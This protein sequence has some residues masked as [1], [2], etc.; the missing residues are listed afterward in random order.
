MY[1][2]ARERPPVAVQPTLAEQ[3]AG[4]ERM[5]DSTAEPAEV[6]FVDVD[7]DGVRAQ[8][9]VPADAA[10]DRVL[11]YFH[12]GGYA[13]CSMRSHSKLVGH[14]ATA[15]GCRGLNVDYRLAPEHPHP[16][17]I[18]DG[19]TAYRWLLAQGLDP[20]HIAVAG[21]SAGGGLAAA[22]LLKAR[23]DGLPLPAAGV[24]LSPWVDLELT[25]DSVTTRVGRDLLVDAD[26]ARMCAA[27]FLAGQDPREPY[28]SP[29][30][31]DLS[32]LPP[33]YIQVGDDE[34]FLDDAARL[35]NKA[36]RA[37][38]DVRLDVFPEMQHEFQMFAG[39]MPE[40]DDAVTRIGA[41]LRPRLGLAGESQ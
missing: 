18:A 2:Q 31:G 11:V 7:A 27:Q 25:G 39:N 10:D 16:A 6:T 1:R 9:A 29:L 26:G 24:L 30:H 33:L 23:D 32:G 38:V 13:Y 19:V 22:L 3:R 17:P 21:D 36:R 15:I 37:G 5:G 12:G 14:L 8:W 34:L 40:A 41:F 35:T 28:A 20:Q 4:A